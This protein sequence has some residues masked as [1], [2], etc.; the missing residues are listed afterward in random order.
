[1]KSKEVFERYGPYMQ[2]CIELARKSEGARPFIGS[3]VISESG[4][5]TEGYRKHDVGINYLIHAERE[6]LDKTNGD[7]RN[8]TLVTTL[9]PCVQL[10]GNQLFRS[11]SDIIIKLGI[12]RVVL[13]FVK[14]QYRVRFLQ[15]NGVEVLVCEG[16]EEVIK[17]DL[18]PLP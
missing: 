18:M 3:L 17:R 11:C 9:E 2:R 16:F 14:E 12:K 8:G 13:G 7:A 4:K 15:K 10:S 6:A 1:M 5:I